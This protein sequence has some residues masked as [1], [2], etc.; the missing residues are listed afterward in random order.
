[1][2]FLVHKPDLWPGFIWQTIET[3]KLYTDGPELSDS[4]ADR[5][6]FVPGGDLVSIG[7]KSPLRNDQIWTLDEENK[8]ERI[9][10]KLEPFWREEKLKSK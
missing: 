4:S 9:W 5:M 7:A 6:F 1:M 2:D 3:Q 10:E 8:A